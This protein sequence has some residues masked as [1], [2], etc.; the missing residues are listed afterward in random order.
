ML[1]RATTAISA[2]KSD[3]T[4][5]S[6]PTKELVLKS[7]MTDLVSTTQFPFGVIC[8]TPAGVTDP[9]SV[10]FERSKSESI[11]CPD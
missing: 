4:H 3:D 10:C 1:G 5:S 2:P 11:I 6:V 7:A 9:V 8:F